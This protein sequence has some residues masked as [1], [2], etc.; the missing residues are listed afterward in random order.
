MNIPAKAWIFLFFVCSL[1]SCE[2]DSE[3]VRNVSE[4]LA[5]AKKEIEVLA[6]NKREL[7]DELG[8]IWVRSLEYRFPDVR[9]I[10][11]GD[12]APVTLSELPYLK[13]I[14]FEYIENQR[15]KMQCFYRSPVKAKVKFTLYLF[16]NNFGINIYRADIED[17]I[18]KEQ[19]TVIVHEI[20]VK[21]RYTPQ[22]F[23]IRP[24]K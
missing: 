3:R 11:K 8:T 2:S 12:T 7:E 4:A 22:F 18:K 24:I 16:D 6:H 5:K 19:E 13:A 10:P 21:S 20:E 14:S 1:L 23:M 15:L 9:P 17:T